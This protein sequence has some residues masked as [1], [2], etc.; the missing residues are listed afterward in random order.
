MGEF[1]ADAREDDKSQTEPE[2]CREGEEYRFKERRVVLRVQFRHAQNSAVRCDE[3]QKY[4][5]SGM[6]RR[7][8]TLHC[9][10]DELNERR[11]DKDER[12]GMDVIETMGLQN[13]II[14]APCDGCGNRHDKNN[15]ARHSQGGTRL[16]RHSKERAT[17]QK[18]VENEVVH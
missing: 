10:I 15:S 18:A 6:K 5:Q 9:N 4:A 7:H 14:N 3:R 17:T 13:E 11:N 1:F 2:R 12:Q 8:E 16:F